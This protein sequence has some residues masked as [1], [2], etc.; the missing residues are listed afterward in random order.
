MRRGVPDEGRRNNAVC[1]SYPQV[2]IPS[3]DDCGIR[4]FA[5]LVFQGMKH[6]EAF[7][8]P[9]DGNIQ[10]RT[11]L[12]RVIVDQDYPPVAQ[13]HNINSGVWIGQIYGPRLRPGHTSVPGIGNT[14]LSDARRGACIEPQP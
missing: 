4:I 5:R 12:C 8:I 9:A 6:P 7:S 10:R 11:F 3:L 13:R 14:D 2:A 1:P